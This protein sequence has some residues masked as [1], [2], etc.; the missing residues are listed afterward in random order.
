MSWARSFVF[1]SITWRARAEVASSSMPVVREPHPAEHG[2]QRRAQ[3]MRDDGE[4]SILRLVRVVQLAP[5]FLEV[6]KNLLVGPHVAEDADRADD[7]AVCVPQRRG[8]QA[9]SR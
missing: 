3:L 1:R 2:G 5:R 9:S 7:V 4:E 6:M 8:V